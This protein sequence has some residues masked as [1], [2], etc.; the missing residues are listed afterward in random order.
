MIKVLQG[1]EL[2][3]EIDRLSNWNVT[4]DSAALTRSYK[5]ADFVSAFEFMKTVAVYADVVDHHPEWFNV[6]N[7]VDITLTTHDAGGITRKDVSMA[8]FMN[9]AARK[10]GATVA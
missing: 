4:E 8:Q 1:E 5:F 3:D 7:R 9:R 2:T 10:R 6:Y